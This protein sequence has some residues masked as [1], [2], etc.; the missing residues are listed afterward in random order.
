MVT[1]DKTSTRMRDI[2]RKTPIILIERNIDR[3]FIMN[4]RKYICGILEA[5]NV[6]MEAY[7]D[8]MA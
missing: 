1:V 8:V 5:S 4:E 7:H 3:G 2:M 6:V